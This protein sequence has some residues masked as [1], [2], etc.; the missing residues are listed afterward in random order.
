[1][2]NGLDNRLAS[3]KSGRHYPLYFG[4]CIYHDQNDDGKCNK[5]LIGIPIEPYAFSNNFRPRF[6]KPKFSD[7][8]FYAKEA[9]TITIYMVN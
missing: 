8:S 9:K 2:K 3:I 6:S 4:F 7:G 1:M 5:N